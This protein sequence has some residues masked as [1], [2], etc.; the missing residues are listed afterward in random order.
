MRVQKCR[1]NLEQEREGRRTKKIEEALNGIEE[2][3]RV[4][5]GESILILGKEDEGCDEYR[6]EKQ[7]GFQALRN[8]YLNTTSVK[9]TPTSPPK[10]TG[11][12]DEKILTFA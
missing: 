7:A 4:S 1:R 6:S 10:R 12:R 9:K 2:I 3:Q 11:G 5:R 8:L